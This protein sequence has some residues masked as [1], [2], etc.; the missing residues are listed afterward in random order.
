MIRAL[1]T[2]DFDAWLAL[3]DGYLAF[4][5]EEL[6]AATTRRTFDRLCSGEEMFAFVAEE[7]GSLV[8]LVHTLT[9]A[10]TWSTATYC[11]LEDLYVAEAGRG[12][13][14]GRDLIEAVA[15][16]AAER[17]AEK[18]Y[19]HTQEYNGRARS[20][21]DQVANRTSFIVYER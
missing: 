15:A 4:Y 12:T 18:V 8:G 14:A 6:P 21:Y 10:S 16:E 20:L 2:D 7:G 17:G 19:W 9:H 5:R 11:Y 3:W 1:R 13:S